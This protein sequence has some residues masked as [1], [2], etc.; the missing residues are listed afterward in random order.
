MPVL[1][2]PVRAHSLGRSFLRLDCE[3]SR[4]KLILLLAAH[5]TRDTTKSFE[6]AYP[7]MKWAALAFMLS[8][9]TL[10]LLFRG[11]L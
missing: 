4:A 5:A 2:Q 1:Q 6:E 10:W 11:F 9:F 3:A 7:F 8:A